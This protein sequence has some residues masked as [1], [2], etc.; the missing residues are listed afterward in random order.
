[1]WHI[2]MPGAGAIHSIN[3][4]TLA[5][6]ADIHPAII[7]LPLLS[8][9]IADAVLGAE[10]CDGNPGLVL[11]QNAP[12]FGRFLSQIACRAMDDLV[13]GEPAML[14][15]WSFRL[16]QCLPQTGYGRRGNG[17]RT[18]N[19]R[20]QEIRHAFRLCLDETS[21]GPREAGQ[22]VEGIG[23]ARQ[24]GRRPRDRIQ[25]KRAWQPEGRGPSCAA[26]A[27]PARFRRYDGLSSARSRRAVLRCVRTGSQP[28]GPVVTKCL[29]PARLL[30]RR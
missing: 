27:G 1:M 9:R 22:E 10:I 2:A 26:A 15:L 5:A 23:Y 4:A 13:F 25:Q 12:F 29:H 19:A 28:N 11:L 14:D 7:G 30:L 18:A 20:P 16:S 24:P 6:L 3:G 8:S 17:C 21:R